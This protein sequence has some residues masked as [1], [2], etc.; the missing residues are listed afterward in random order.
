MG[1]NPPRGP[2]A[3]WWVLMTINAA[4]TNGLTWLPKHGKSYKVIVI[5]LNT[6]FA[7]VAL[8]TNHLIPCL[9]IIYVVPISIPFIKYPTSRFKISRIDTDL[10]E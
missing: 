6:E 1:H 5:K 9:K 4:G 8:Q 2:S 10:N 3:G 7:S